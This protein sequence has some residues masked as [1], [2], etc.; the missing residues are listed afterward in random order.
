MSQFD[1]EDLP[2]N[3]SNNEHFQ[4]VVERVISRRRFLK[5]GAGIS[6]AAFLGGA[7]GACGGNSSSNTADRDGTP[8]GPGQSLLGFSPVEKYTGDK[9]IVPAGYSAAVLAPWG[10]PLFSTTSPYR[11]DAT[12]TATDQVGATP[13]DRPEWISVHPQTGEVYCTLTNNR[14]RAPSAVD[15][16]NPR[17]ENIYGHIVN[18][19]EAGD[20]AAALEFEWDLFVLAG[21]PS[22]YPAPDP[23][24]GSASVTQENAFNS[25]DG[26]AFDAEGRLWIQTDGNDSDVGDF[27][28]QGNN[29]MLAADPAT[30]GIRRFLYGPKGCE[31]TGITWTPDMKTMFVNIQHPGGAWPKSQWDDVAGGSARPRSATVVITKDDGG[32][33]GT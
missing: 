33:I 12:N 19:R 15:G 14:G 3:L 24:A 20:D 26:L 18:W 30:G 8:G 9:V 7:L 1:P 4:S 16:V 2:A 6:A 25:P 10:T 22:V 17:A 13:M 23:R 11:D 27:A 29:Q 5:I 21:N 31:V 32:V 28:G